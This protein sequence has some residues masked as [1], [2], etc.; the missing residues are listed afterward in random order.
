MSLA[1]TADWRG[2]VRQV[3][4]VSPVCCSCA[5]R[6]KAR[7]GTG[8]LGAYGLEA[9]G[10]VAIDFLDSRPRAA[11][12]PRGRDQAPTHLDRMI[13]GIQTDHAPSD[14][15]GRPMQSD[16]SQ[17]LVAAAHKRTTQTRRA[18]RSQHTAGS[19]TTPRQSASTPSPAKPGSPAR[20]SARAHRRCAHVG[21]SSGA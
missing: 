3:G 9:V 14:L 18:G 13:N 2:G 7:G 6:G 11:R 20:P 4:D 1:G 21:H 17:H 12:T 10:V 16:N 19:P 15:D 5:E 8:G